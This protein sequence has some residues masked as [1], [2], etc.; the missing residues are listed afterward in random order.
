MGMKRGQGRL[1]PSSAASQEKRLSNKKE[2]YGQSGELTARWQEEAGGADGVTRRDGTAD[3]SCHSI[4]KTADGGGAKPAVES[5]I[6]HGNQLL[7]HLAV[8]DERR[9]L[10]VTQTSFL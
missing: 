8:L 5:N 2:N 4:V 1:Q 10:G 3:T 6:S 7:L 9:D